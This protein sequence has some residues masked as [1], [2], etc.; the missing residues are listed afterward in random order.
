[1]Q[2]NIPYPTTLEDKTMG[3]DYHLAHNYV[4]RAVKKGL[5]PDLKKLTV[6]CF[7]CGSRATVFD[8]RDYSRFLDVEPVCQSCNI[9]RGKAKKEKKGKYEI[10]RKEPRQERADMKRMKSAAQAAAQWSCSAVWVRRLCQHGRIREAI[11]V[12]RD[13]VMPKNAEYPRLYKRGRKPA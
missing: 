7:D 9:K 4:C 5:L 10:V 8:H 1:V 12:G 2:L 6:K 11:K 3:G 13:W